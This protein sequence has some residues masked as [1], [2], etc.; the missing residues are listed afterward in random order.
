MFGTNTLTLILGLVLFSFSVTSALIIPFIDLLYKLK[1]LRLKEAPKKGKVP[2]IDKLLDKKAG[3]PTGGGILLV[4][5]V[6]TI[7]MVVFK[8]LVSSGFYVQSSHDLNWEIGILLFTFVSY[9][10]LG[11]SDDWLKIF[12]KPKKGT[13]GMWVGLGR[14]VKFGMQWLLAILIALLIYKFLG[15][16]IIHIPILDVVVNLG[17]FYIP[18]AAFLIVFLANAFNL[19]D[20]LDGLSCGLLVIFLISYIFITATALD[21]PLSV[22]I[23]LWIGVLIAFLYFNVWPARIILGDTGALSFGATVAVIGLLTGSVAAIFVIG[24]LFVIEA[25]SSAIQILGWKALNRPIFP[26][27]PIHHT[28]LALGWEEPK[29]VMRAWLAGI[30]LAILGLWISSI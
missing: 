29:I 22:F 17:V 15:V 19:T 4:I 18:F 14:K 30:V 13:L 27:A 8:V 6:S 26:I 1:F 21:T 11:L 20:G 7:F 16:S 10:L 24:G 2:L 28:F 25:I 23:S 3:V 5:V 9:A 12:G